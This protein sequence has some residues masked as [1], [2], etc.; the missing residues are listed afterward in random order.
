LHAGQR[1]SQRSRPRP[2]RAHSSQPAPTRRSRAAATSGA[3]I[4]M[5]VGDRHLSQRARNR[6]G[7]RIAAVSGIGQSETV[8][9]SRT[10]GS[11][12]PRAP[13]NDTDRMHSQGGIAPDPFREGGASPVPVA[14]EAPRTGELEWR[15]APQRSEGEAREHQFGRKVQCPALGELSRPRLT[16]G[17]TRMSPRPTRPGLPPRARLFA[18]GPLLQ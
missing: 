13:I 12:P 9:P 7:V 16:Q 1:H 17:R 15:L 5:G 11:H 18:R 3:S 2:R 6:P 8:T 14:R 4:S 10:R